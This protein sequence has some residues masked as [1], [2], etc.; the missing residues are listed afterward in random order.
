MGYHDSGNLNEMQGVSFMARPQL[1]LDRYRVIGKAGA[2]GYGTVQHAYD[3]RLKRDV[4]IKCIEL[5][6]ADAARAHLVAMEEHMQNEGAQWGGE[7]GAIGRADA[8]RQGSPDDG[9][10]NA[11]GDEPFNQVPGLEEARTAAHLNDANIVT[12]YDC[13]VH[14]STAYVI[15]EYI[16]GKTLG[17]ILDE[18]DDEI[19]LDVVAAVFTAIAHAL[20]VAHSNDVLH[21]DI[22]PENVIVNEKGVVKVTDFGLAKLTDASGCATS[23]GG[24]ISYMPPEQIRQEP[25]DVRTDEWALASLTYEML[26]GSN[27]FVASNL[28]DAERV[29]MNA[30]LVLPSLC[31]DELDTR[32]DDVIFKALDPDPN[33]RYASVAAFAG[34]LTPLLGNAQKGRKVLASVVKGEPLPSNNTTE[35]VEP[36][37][38]K[39]PVI[40]RMGSRGA[41]VVMHIVAALGV[42]AIAAVSLVDIRFGMWGTYG[43]ASEHAVIF[44]VALA[45]CVV[46][47]A[48]RPMLGMI[49]G[50]VL[51]AVMLLINHAYIPG[52]VMLVVTVLWW[53]WCGRRDDG[54]CTAALLQPLTGSF[55]MAALAPVACGAFLTVRNATLTAIFSVVCAVAFAS[56]GSGDLMNWNAAANAL[57]AVD[58][59]I[60]G[61][62]ITNAF[63][64][65]IT[66]PRTW[67]IGVSWVLAA[68]FFALLCKRGTRSFDI[69]GAIV[70]V[71]VLLLGVILAPGVETLVRAILD[72]GSPLASIASI[73]WAPRPLALAGVLVPG[74]IGIVLA[75]MNVPNRVRLGKG[76]W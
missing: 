61:P 33:R 28:R 41:A 39:P 71:L 70:A 15:M 46:L 12:V 59:S 26:S 40:D 1:I 65:A 74:I 52:I 29:I 6:E 7:T 13:E 38:D 30:E 44:W 53:L 35:V 2:G 10:G 17:R 57:T 3:T 36:V 55:A 63:V 51:F 5:S 11:T 73:S 62:A 72:T 58:P 9:S 43:L 20:E 8:D 37:E 4:A 16:E 22:K 48:I 64:A 24:T 69:A 25:L 14:G 23:G 32:A 60:G 31:W 54:A 76:K 27:P 68:V 49:V 18:M 67:C 75:L 56:L 19:S 34:A 47:A 42:A 21:L 66:A 45:V 50:F